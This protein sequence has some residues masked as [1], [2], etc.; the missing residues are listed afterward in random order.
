M[1]HQR[2]NKAGALVNRNYNE[3]ISHNNSIGIFCEQ[4]YTGARALKMCGPIQKC[5]SILWLFLLVLY[6]SCTGNSSLLKDGYYTAEAADFDSFGWKEYV[7]IRVSGGQITLVEY[8]AF[9]PSGFIKSWDMDYM[10]LMGALGETYPNAYTRYYGRQLF[11]KQGT[12]GVDRL[13]G[14]TN[15]YNTFLQL[16]DAA[17]KNAR[18]G[19]RETRLVNLA[20]AVNN[21]VNAAR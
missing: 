9:N 5:V 19:D 8:N 12:S 3:T 11:E 16:A 2:D 15:S 13:S 4:C 1:F 7:T 17:L 10:R 14:A 6:I 20:E 18:R 21:E